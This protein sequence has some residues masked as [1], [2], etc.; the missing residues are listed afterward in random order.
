[1]HDLGLTSR[2]VRNIARALADEPTG[3]LDSK[4]KFE[5][6]KLIRRLSFQQGMTT[7]MVTHDT[8]VA[9][10]S[11]RVIVIKDGRTRLNKHQAQASI[12]EQEEEEELE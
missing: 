5:I 9:S 3:N 1:V 6:I 12:E 7:I 2:A 11:G 8:R 10:M 4:N